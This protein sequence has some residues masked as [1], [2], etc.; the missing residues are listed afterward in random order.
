MNDFVNLSSKCKELRKAKGWSQ[1][2]LGKVIESNQT[3]ISFIER[4]FIP[5]DITK[6]QAIMALYD[7]ACKYKMSNT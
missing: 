5:K 2:A 3:E 7:N 1:E 6:V 4:G